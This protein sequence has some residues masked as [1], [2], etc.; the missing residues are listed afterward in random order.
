MKLVEVAVKRPV[1]TIMFILAIIV[2][3][4]ISLKKLPIDLMP[5]IS[6][7]TVTIKTEWTGVAP[8]EIELLV[9]KPIEENISTI[10]GLKNMTSYSKPGVSVITL[11]FAWGT[12]M[13]TTVINLREMLDKIYFPDDVDK[14]QIFRYNPNL[15]PVL[16]IAFYSSKNKNLSDIRAFLEDDVKNDLLTLDGVASVDVKGGVKNELLIMVNTLKLASLNI[17][18]NN[19]YNK[20]NN[21]NL[22][23]AAGSIEERDSEYLVRLVSKFKTVDDVKNLI[24]AMRDNKPIRLKEV[25]K[26]SV[27]PVDDVDITKLNG[28][29]AVFVEIYKTSGANSVNVSKTVQRK[30][31]FLSRKFKGLNYKIITD[32]SVFIAS[33]IADVF[34]SAFWGGILAVLIIFL[35]LK[36]IKATTIISLAIPVSVIS[37]FFAMYVKHISL[38]IMSIGGIALGIGMLVDSAIVVLES[39]DRAKKKVDISDPVALGNASIKGTKVVANAVMASTLTTIAVFIPIVFV[40]GIS[41]KLFADQA[42]TVTFALV[43]SLLVAI[44]LIPM[45]A[46]LT[47]KRK[48]LVNEE[49]GEANGIEKKS[50]G[51]IYLPERIFHKIFSFLGKIYGKILD[52]NLYIL[53]TVF[54]RRKKSRFLQ[55]ILEKFD[56]YFE[57]LRKNYNHILLW[58][59]KNRGKTVLYA[60]LLLLFSFILIPF[61]GMELIPEVSQSEFTVEIT[62][63]VGV[64]EADLQRFLNDFSDR[65]LNNKLASIVYESIGKGN[66]PLK[67]KDSATVFVK[68]DKNIS[69]EHGIENVRKILSGYPGVSYE[70][71]FP[72]IF[73][74]NSVPL[75]IEIYG[76]NIDKLR[77]ITALLDKKLKN[78]HELKDINVLIKKG[79]P[80]VVLHFNQEK[81]AHFN[82]DVQTVSRLLELEISGENTNRFPYKG[83]EI[84]IHLVGR[85]R[86]LKNYQRLSDFLIPV[87]NQK[88]PL[89]S[90]ASIK[91]VNGPSEI[92]RKDEER[93]SLITADYSGA[94]LEKVVKK[95]KNVIKNIKLPDGYRIEIG[96]D[97][98]EMG[99]SSKSMQFAIFLAIFLVY[100]V[101]ASQFESFLHPFIILFAIPFSLIGVIIMLFIT[102]NSISV[103]SLIGVVMLAGIVVNNGIVLV[104]YINQLRRKHHYKKYDAIVEAAHTRLRPILMTTLTTVLGLLPMAL[105]SGDGSELRTPLAWTVIGGLLSSTFLTLVFVPVI[106]S[107]ME[108]EK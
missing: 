15:D 62:P 10:A 75:Q 30:L 72:K 36:D 48:R 102:G 44:S 76:K 40:E 19:L 1:T 93:V 52:I 107:L 80:E 58:A 25:A 5:D 91:V 49:L 56:F 59:L 92:I 87:G 50:D 78:I 38:N 23:F 98:L 70:V 99:K 60:L 6:Y 101:M 108:R 13:D 46:S 11:E 9:T 18:I 16:Q 71:K 45:L 14:P 54:K 103:I 96:G 63:N 94:S 83:R 41:G 4:F 17:S 86:T 12:D 3:G 85:G 61:L 32:K 21:E 55:F 8:E 42:F 69:N 74:T 57:K 67:D 26:V 31:K 53:K 29:D 90:V 106:Y 105:V 24:I 65:L 37:V 100:I 89:K 97:A 66:N 33:S 81:L 27:A 7:P 20:L 84:D 35:F 73:D 51:L 88:I 68:L 39:I 95:V 79:K 104:D 47:T 28:K 43:A 82:L 34:S 2:F 22:S 64:G 77:E